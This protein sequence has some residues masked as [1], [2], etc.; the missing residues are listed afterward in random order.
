[1]ATQPI[2]HSLVK[3]LRAVADFAPL[4]D[5][6]LLEIV[7][8][9][10]CLF[11]SADSAVFAKGDPADALYV[12]LSGRVRIFERTDGAEDEIAHLEPGDYFGEQSL[13]FHTTHSTNV[14]TVEDSE[15]MVIPRA[16]FEPILTA[17]PNLAD[18][19]RQ[20][21]ESRILSRHYR[22]PREGTPAHRP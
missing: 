16:S 15:L 20:K 5:A 3:A 6:T 18:R 10:A 13:L 7:G 4:D 21:L 9:S 14:H 19:F 1:M 12:V 17:N 22:P 11:W 8:D 2:T